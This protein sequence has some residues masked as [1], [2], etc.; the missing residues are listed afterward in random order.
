MAR[1]RHWLRNETAPD[2]TPLVCLY[3]GEPTDGQ[4]CA[5][6]SCECG[7][8][9]WVTQ[10]WLPAVEAGDL[11]PMCWWCCEQTSQTGAVIDVPLRYRRR[12]ADLARVGGSEE[13]G[14]L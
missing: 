11:I 8:Q 2:E 7:A 5:V 3:F 1:G 13:L 10:V 12:E 6:R 4:L 14:D 9:L